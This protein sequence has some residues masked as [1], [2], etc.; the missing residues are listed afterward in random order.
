[1]KILVLNGSPKGTNS[2]TL[3]TVL[4]LEKVYKNVEFEY[5]H[6]GMKIKAYEKDFNKVKDSLKDAEIIL[7]AYPVYTF[8]APAQVHRFIELIK[9]S[10]IDFSGKIAT[11]ITTSK[12]FFDV[13]AHKYIEENCL[14]MGIKFVKGLSADMDDLYHENGPREAKMFFEQ[15]LFAIKNDCF[16]TREPIKTLVKPV[17]EPTLNKTEKSKNYDVVILTNYSKDDINL[18][19][20]I[21]DFRNALPSKSRIVNIKD[22]SFSAGCLG[23][24]KCT[25]TGKCIHKDNFDEFLR[26]EVQ[27]ADAI[28]Y[29]FTIKDHF[30]DSS[31]KFYDDRQFC[32]GHRQVTEGM[33]VAYLLSGNYSNEP[34]L[35]MVIEGRCEVGGTYLAGIATD[36]SENT[37]AEIQ[38]L[39]NELIFAIDNKLTRPRNFY[40][41]GGNKIFRDLVYLMQGMMKADHKFYKQHGYYDFPQN[42]KGTILGM[43]LIGC[44]MRNKKLMKKMGNMN[45]YILMPYKKVIDELDK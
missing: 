32:N 11:Q 42:K 16:I 29:A 33:Q 6:I 18:Q 38:K 7:F 4:Y 31:M 34:N 5:L 20:M 39:A 15:L 14:D 10:G 2:I 12:H 25:A 44:I 23:C 30:T 36:E 35:Q 41:V 45:Q 26:N 28:V 17:Y 24:F 3:Q 1:M 27:I 9:A 8:L 40:G 22:F 13:T 19:N 43:K 37:C 21:T